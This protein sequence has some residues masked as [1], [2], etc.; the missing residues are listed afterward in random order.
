[1]GLKFIKTLNAIY[2]L[3]KNN[4]YKSLNKTKTQLAIW[5]KKIIVRRANQISELNERFKQSEKRAAIK[6]VQ[7]NLKANTEKQNDLKN[8]L[9][10]L[11]NQCKGIVDN[12]QRL[13]TPIKNRQIDQKRISK[14]IWVLGVVL[15][16][17]IGWAFYFI[18]L[19]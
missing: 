17:I 13:T 1:M 16:L 15:L 3:M 10:G 12:H 14:I 6:N 2:I 11:S 19:V 7:M 9:E 4:L 8:E 18:F 5:L